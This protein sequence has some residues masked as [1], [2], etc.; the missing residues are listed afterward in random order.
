MVSAHVRCARKVA[1]TVLGVAALCA[2]SL[3]GV[4]VVVVVLD[5]PG[6]EGVDQW[7]EHDCT[8]NVLY[9]VILAEAAVAAVVAHDEPLQGRHSREEGSR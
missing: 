5:A 1:D 6:L 2:H 8:H 7:R 3:V 4:C 9:Q